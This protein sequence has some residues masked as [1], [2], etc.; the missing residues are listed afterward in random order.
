MFWQWQLI[1]QEPNH[2]AEVKP[3]KSGDRCQE[4]TQSSQEPITAS[5]FIIG[6]QYL[7]EFSLQARKEAVLDLGGK[8]VLYHVSLDGLLNYM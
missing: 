4:D 7:V 2:H 3:I 6:G 1:L 5:L 8:P